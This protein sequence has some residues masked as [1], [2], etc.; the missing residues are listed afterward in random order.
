MWREIK[1]LIIDDDQTRRHDLKVIL[2]FLGEEAVSLTSQDWLAKSK[3]SFENSDEVVAVM[4]GST[5][6]SS[7]EMV[8]EIIGWDNGLP[9]VFLG[10]SQDDS[11]FEDDFKRRVIGRIALPPSYNKLLDT[12]HRAQVYR[13][14]YDLTRGRD[15]RREPQLFR[16]LVGSSRAVQNVR[17]M[18]AQVAD[19]DVTVLIQ[20]ES[21]TGKEVVARNLH[22]NS[23]RRNKPFVPINCGAIP[24]ELLESELFGHEKG[25]FTGAV[26]ARAGRFE[27]A[28]GGTLFLDEI[29]DMPLAMQVKLLRVLQEH[30]YE[31]VGGN[32]TLK[33]DVRIVA[34]THRNLDLMIE[35]NTFRE[36]LY[37][38]LN[39]FPIDMPAL[40]ERYED[41]PILLNE[42]I[43]RLENEKRG[44]IRFNSAA[45]MSIARH[46]WPGNIREMANLVER[47]AI[48]HPFGVI[49]VQELPKKYRHI[50]DHDE[51]NVKDN[52]PQFDVSKMQPISGQSNTIEASLDQ[53]ALLP[54]NGLDLKEYLTNLECN[55]IKQALDDANGVV[56]RAAEKLH[57][58]RTTL[59][60]KMRKYQLN[61]KEAV[62]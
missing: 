48:L 32:K 16:S 46:D 27:L 22:Y 39:V 45:I 4:L 53:Q 33:T 42:L 5:Q 23:T 41:I 57:I 21:G 36:D 56:A 26:S 13:E 55:L 40:R 6:T 19:K 62:G 59:V 61:R 3:E 11:E 25:A 38:R 58:R 60:E 31:R 47:L 14:Q 30:T 37:Y 17:E 49:G 1:V 34:A 50:D 52:M 43:S 54:V 44:S 10:Q 29:G 12:L 20:G 2:D 24:S 35:Q 8:K 15:S 51:Q 9:I 7:I 28:E 18:M